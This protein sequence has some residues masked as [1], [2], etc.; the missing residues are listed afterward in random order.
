MNTDH[1]N[2]NLVLNVAPVA[3]TAEPVLVTAIP[4]DERRLR[5]LREQHSGKYLFRR[6]GPNEI[7]CIRLSEEA[8]Q[9]VGDNRRISLQDNLR[10]AANLTREL[11]LNYLFH[12]GRRITNFDPVEFLTAGPD[13][14]LLRAG[15]SSCPEWLS[16]RLLYRIDARVFSFAKRRPFVGLAVEL[17]T[18]RVVTRS[19]AQLIADGMD[20]RGL[21]VRRET[22]P[23]DSR[24]HP[25]LSLAGRVVECSGDTL[26]LDDSAFAESILRSDEAYI[27]LNHTGFSRCMSHVFGGTREAVLQ[28]LDERIADIVSGPARLRLITRVIR[29]LSTRTELST[30]DGVRL[31]IGGL[32]TSE[33]VDF[34]DLI[35]APKPIYTFDSVGKTADKWQ[36]RGLRKHG[37]YSRDALTQRSYKVC[38]IC[39]ASH[40]EMTRRFMERFLH[41]IPSTARGKQNTF[42]DGFTSRY[43][44]P[45]IEVDYFPAKNNSPEEYMRATENSLKTH[46]ASWDISMVQIEAGFKD[47]PPQ[48][49]PYLLTKS[50]FLS[51]QIPSQEF[52][53][54][55]MSLPDQRLGYALNNMGLAVYAKLGGIPWALRSP[56]STGAQELV[57]GLGSA[58]IGEARLSSRERVVGVTTVFSGDGTYQL[59][60]LSRAVPFADYRPTLV[61]TVTGAMEEAARSLDWDTNQPVRLIFHYSFKAFSRDDV[62]SVRDGITALGRFQP[63][64]AFLNIIEDPPYRLFDLRQQGVF[65]TT[66]RKFKGVYAPE[67]SEYIPISHSETLLHL[68]GPRE[69]KQ[70]KHGMPRPSLLRLHPESTFRDMRYIVEQVFALSGHS[71]QGF[72][73][74]AHPVTIQY[75]DLIAKQ[76]GQLSRLPNWNPSALLGLVGRSRWFL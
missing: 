68:T 31:R 3:P 57:V 7:L 21:Y 1:G 63:V 13:H 18:R 37:P 65:D 62:G 23:P 55:T 76:L 33:H 72:H 14:N 52:T 9:V 49:N 35:R 6:D 59:S 67:R 70:Q 15:G 25:R 44:I 64:F 17:K 16:V 61:E 60:S 46:S 19:C 73:P 26:I 24:L 10:L 45:E 38:V 36:D 12:A 42:S 4:Y 40:L 75:S 41:G 56:R 66:T 69:L 48:D 71:W 32:L 20:V 51:Q 50:A 53:V 11:L 34:P 54:D 22:P 29:Y 28:E 39:N 8:E 74:C 43:R 58:H 27:D 2:S 47:L 30:P 5:E